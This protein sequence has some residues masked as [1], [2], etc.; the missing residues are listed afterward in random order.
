MSIRIDE[1]AVVETK[2]IGENTI[3]WRWSHISKGV[4][5]G[6]NCMIGQG[7]YIGPNVVIGDYVR[8]QNNAY[9]PELVTLED[10]VFLG[11]S[12]VFINFKY[13]VSR[14]EGVP[15]KSQ[16]LPTLVKKGA[17]IGANATIL[18]GITIHEESLVGAG[19][20]VTKDVM[21][22]TIVWGNPAE[23]HK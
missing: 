8:I 19:S 9:V 23:C 5:I 15:D 11:P 17:S 18:C 14:K 21:P 13:P 7:V 3:I 12:C 10:E 2:E 4:K 16:W 1:N 22:N 20:V 6:K